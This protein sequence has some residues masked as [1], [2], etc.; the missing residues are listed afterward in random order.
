MQ[1]KA[2]FWFQRNESKLLALDIVCV[3]ILFFLHLITSSLQILLP[4]IVNAIQVVTLL[5]VSLIALS[6]V[7]KGAVPI[8]ICVLGI[9]LIHNSVILPY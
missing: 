8:I 9:V 3:V 6:V 5:L 2:F 4:E 7:W 1:N